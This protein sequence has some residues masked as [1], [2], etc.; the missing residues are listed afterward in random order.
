MTNKI[1]NLAI[2]AFLVAKEERNQKKLLRFRTAEENIKL[3]MNQDEIIGHIMVCIPLEFVLLSE[4]LEN[5]KDLISFFSTFY[6]IRNEL[7]KVKKKNLFFLL[8]KL[9]L[10]RREFLFL[11]IEPKIKFFMN[12]LN[13]Y[14]A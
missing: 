2:N 1:E 12:L 11:R 6:Y 13:F 14:F 3:P 8:P 5:S 4:V 9:P 7:V 10:F